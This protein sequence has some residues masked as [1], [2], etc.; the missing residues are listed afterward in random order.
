MKLKL[1]MTLL[2]INL[3]IC[4]YSEVTILRT[5]AQECEP[6]YF[7][8]DN[9]EK[10]NGICVDVMR[11]IENIDPTIKFIGDQNFIP[12]QRIEEGV[13]KGDYDCFVGFAMNEERIKKYKFI[14]IPIYYV[15]NILISRIDEDINVYDLSQLMYLDDN[16]IMMAMGIA[17]ADKLKSRGYNIDDGAHTPEL[18]I[19][20]LLSNRGRFIYQSEIS[21]MAAI[22]KL[23]VGDSIKVHPLKQFETG[24]YIAFYPGTPAKIIEKV[25]SALEKLEKQGVL[26]EIFKKYVSKE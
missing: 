8:L 21:L 24:R 26:E 11:A 23:G 14:D 6:K 13:S 12:F 9:E 7:R 17:Q 19:K 25:E 20:K 15:R 3:I 2:I 4:M 10:I 22:K 1:T 16:V 18:N 5:A